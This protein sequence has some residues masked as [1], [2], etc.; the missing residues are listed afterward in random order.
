MSAQLYQNKSATATL[1]DIPRSIAFAQGTS[2]SSRDGTLFSSPPLGVPWPSTEPVSEK[3]KANVASRG[4]ARSRPTAEEQMLKVLD[5][6][7]TVWKSEWCLERQLKPNCEEPE[8]STPTRSLTGWKLLEPLLLK[9]NPTEPLLLQDILS[10]PVSNPAPRSTSLRVIAD[11]EHGL[12]P[13]RLHSNS[14]CYRV[15][16]YECSFA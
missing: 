4:M 9:E 5:E 13:S 11:L 16:V 12:K 6:L 14:V 8:L 2:D 1:L 3:A 15:P 10:R 7:K